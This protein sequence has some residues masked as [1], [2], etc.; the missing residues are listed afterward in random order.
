MCG[1]AG[2]AYSD[3][4]TSPEEQTLTRMHQALY[5][6]GPDD[7]GVYVAPGIGLAFSRLS[8]IDLSGGHQ[9]MCNEDG[10]VWIV[11]NGEIYNFQALRH[12]LQKRGHLFKTGSDTEVII[13][14]YEQWG[15]DCVQHL[16]GMFAFAIWD[17]NHRRLFLA[18]DHLGI[19]PLFYATLNDK[20]V[21]G[22]EIK[23][24]LPA[25]EHR[26]TI[27][28]DAVREY[29]TYFYVPAPYTIYRE[30]RKLLPGHYLVWSNGDIRT[31]RYWRL[32][33]CAE[34][35]SLA[36]WEEA[37]AAKIEDAVRAQLV[38]DVPVGA[39]L[40]GGIDSSSVVTF[41]TRHQSQPPK[42]FSIGFEVP[43]YNE[44]PAARLVAEHLGTEHHE[45][46][47]RPVGVEF[48]HKLVRQ[49]DEPF[50][51]SSAIPTFLVSH[52]AR[53]HCKVVLSGD[54]G[55]EAFAGYS[56]RTHRFV[57]TAQR[58]P[59]H[60][61]RFMVQPAL[62]LLASGTSNS[63]ALQRLS[64]SMQQDL[65]ER[66]LE[67]HA[68][69]GKAE[70]QRILSQELLSQPRMWTYREVVGQDSGVREIQDPVS[71][72]LYLDTHYHLPNDMLTKVDRTSM[73]NSLEVRVPLLDHELLQLL[74]RMPGKYK[75]RGL[76]NSGTKYILKRVM[77]PLLPRRTLKR[78]KW[79]FEVP[80]WYWFR[81]DWNTLLA[82]IL[83][84]SAM[85]QLGYIDLEAAKG[86]DD[87]G[88]RW[89]LIIFGAW[90]SLC[91]PYVS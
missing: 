14:A 68:F 32:E 91:D 1:I 25:L 56:Y 20:L 60:M 65:V 85:Q 2:I 45:R 21:F 37:V 44:L 28:P 13:H 12:E 86:A 34:E 49:F 29:F 6:R 31:V 15:E 89:A 52:L 9:P 48:I 43:E 40:S 67:A 54:G 71:Q 47:T 3:G 30:L 83:S 5:H 36:E 42:T 27:D 74:A 90:A 61:R 59:V 53:E 41:M 23:G 81:N 51:D 72:M 16:R 63:S 79:G 24:I 17:H 66:W 82:D 57:A 76:G 10:T 46:I 77:A 64:K 80:L 7:C 62:S 69:G 58:L 33:F 75:Q 4:I 73:A 19:K 84:S 26:P 18:R 78:R 88:L 55:D 35:R 50:A 22:S 38:S 11:F 39:F 87:P 70:S 8:I